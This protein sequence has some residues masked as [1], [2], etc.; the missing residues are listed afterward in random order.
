MEIVYPIVM[1]GEVFVVHTVS[2]VYNVF[3]VRFLFFLWGTVAILLIGYGLYFVFRIQV[4]LF[5]GY[6][7]YSVYSCF[8]VI[9]C[10]CYS[11]YRVQL[12]FCFQGTVA[13]LL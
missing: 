9:G 2:S 1:N 7:M 12:L 5:I 3:R 4:V 6:G 10:C 13:F 8:F 11:V